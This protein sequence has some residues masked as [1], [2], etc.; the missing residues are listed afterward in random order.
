MY[1]SHVNVSNPSCADK[2]KGL[3]NVSLYK[4]EAI[5]RQSLVDDEGTGQPAFPKVKIV[6]LE[7]DAVYTW[8][9]GNDP[10]WQA[11]K[12]MTRLALGINDENA[13]GEDAP[14]RYR[15]NDELRYSLRSLAKYAPW[16]RRVHL[17][18]DDQRPD[19]LNTDTVNL[20]HHKDVFPP[21][22]LYPTFNN[23]AIELSMAD[24]PGLTE[25][26]LYFNDDFML[27]AKTNPWD[28]F[29][30]EGQPIIWLRKHSRK[31]WKKFFTRSSEKLNEYDASTRYLYQLIA[32]R[33]GKHIPYK[34]V[35]SPRPMTKFFFHKT[36]MEYEKDFS[37]TMR[38]PFRSKQSVSIAKLYPLYA[39][40]TGY[41][42]LYQL[43]GLN[44]VH[45]FVKKRI[46]HI[47][48][49]LGDNNYHHKLN[50]I[51]KLKPLTFCINDSQYCNDDDISLFQQFMENLFP[52]K[53]KFEV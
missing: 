9:N 51:Q 26:F 43:S 35:H 24:L 2:Y 12:K 11:R 22:I 52:E 10:A 28:F 41:G 4:L 50:L 30:P 47:G 6:M 16:I 27:G 14:C 36:I 45:D 37:T 33:S 44:A 20:L 38:S 49:S 25:H 19:W 31:Y 8:V 1:S 40:A 46:K 32:E 3:R 7:I 34:T 42:Q 48:V 18:T 17:L 53:S 23:R 5:G 29:T 15:D 21:E 39:I 13:S